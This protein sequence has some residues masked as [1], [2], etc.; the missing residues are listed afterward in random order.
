MAKAIGV[1]IKAAIKRAQTWGTAVACGANEGILILPHSLKK[2]RPDLVDD[3]LG[4]YFPHD[5]DHGGIKVEG[6]LKAYL[7]YDSLDLPVA[8][9]MGATGGVPTQPD[10]VN[11]PNTYEQTFSLAESLE[12][13]FATFAI[14]NN[15]NVDEYTSLKL[16]GFTLRGEVGR[17]VEIAFHSI[18]DDRETDSGVNTSGTFA[19][20]TFF[21]T[22]NRVLYSQGVIRMNDS[23]GNALSE[24]DRV[25]PGAF[26]LVFRRDMSG[27]FGVSSADRIDEPTNNG[28]P[29]IRLRL[30]FPRY[31]AS[32]YFSDW[33][34][35]TAKKLDMTFEG[36]VIDT[37]YKRTFKLQ[38]PNL[39]YRDV[40]LPL[41]QGVLGHR[42]EFDCLGT[43]S[44][45]PGMAGITGP[46]QADVTNRQSTDVLA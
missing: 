12:G 8:L 35:N 28:R 22:S 2:Q 45:P 40:E 24:G 42:V 3:S 27:A 37:G 39:R 21:E 16:T 32:T 31:T 17:P 18:A 44:A 15:I 9:A 20:V 41:E 25:Y 34:A 7:R 38:L 36:A 26:E 43:D 19:N 23:S 11:D 5:A 13:L 1:E 6:D 29:E 10:G 14:N 46:F 30:Q 4:L 33:D